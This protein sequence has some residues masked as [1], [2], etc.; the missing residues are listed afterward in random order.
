MD[1]YLTRGIGFNC[2]TWTENWSPTVANAELVHIHSLEIFLTLDDDINATDIWDWPGLTQVISRLPE[3]RRLLL[4]IRSS[5]VP[6]MLTGSDLAG[7]KVFVKQLRETVSV[8][9]IHDHYHSWFSHILD[10]DTFE[11][12]ALL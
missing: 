5:G 2:C 10:A 1:L 3:L 9:I 7:L 8:E 4:C 6:A 11:P 12:G